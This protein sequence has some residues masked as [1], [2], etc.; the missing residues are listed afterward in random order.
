MKPKLIRACTVSNSISFVAGMVPELLRDYK[1]CV[2]ASPGKYWD[3]LDQYGEAVRR[4]EVPMERHISPLRDLRSLWR[5]VRVFRHERPAMVHSMTP[6]A[7]LLC[8]MAAWLC[9]VPVRVHTFTGLVFP[10]ATGLTRRILMLTDSITCACATHIIPEGEG[11]RRDLLNHGITRKPIR[12][13]GYGNCQGIDLQRFD[14]TD[15]TVVTEAERLRKPGVFTF[16]AV[17]RLVGDK[18]INELVSAFTRLNR[19]RPAT[20]LIL[21]GRAEPELDPLQPDTEAEITRNPAIEAVGQQSDVRPW[22]AA[23][24]CAILASYR[25]GFPNVV[26]EAGAMGLPQIV[27][28]INGANEIIIEGENGTIVPPRNPEALYVA[29]KRMITDT[30]W[31]LGLAAKARSMVAS[32]YDQHYV[33]QCLYDFYDKILNTDTIK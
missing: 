18:G 3:S 19:E 25:E 16:I 30:K 32:R 5:L 23:A 8:M 4:I 1:L 9:R 14:P 26:I 29:M 15:S 21:V 20:R 28:A 22:F 7:G 31:R 10:T 24:D 27:T 17:G 11:V 12:V 6:K 2:L 33:R 13:L